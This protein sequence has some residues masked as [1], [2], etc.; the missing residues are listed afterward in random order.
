MGPTRK[1]TACWK[2]G[3]KLSPLGEFVPEF[4]ALSVGATSSIAPRGRAQISETVWPVP[5]NS[6]IDGGAPP[7][8]R[9]AGDGELRRVRYEH[10][11]YAVRIV[12][13]LAMAVLVVVSAVSAN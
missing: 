5:G 4:D 3:R 8:R 12:L 9:S 11:V 1:R 13:S 10:L 7:P 6:H 2:G